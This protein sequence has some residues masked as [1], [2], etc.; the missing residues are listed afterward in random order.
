MILKKGK[1]HEELCNSHCKD[2]RAQRKLPFDIWSLPIACESGYNAI[3]DKRED[4]V[5]YGKARAKYHARTGLPENGVARN[6]SYSV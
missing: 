3:V 2:E 6:C 4:Y 1:A 5:W